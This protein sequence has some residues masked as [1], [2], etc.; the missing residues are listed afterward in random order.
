MR[1]ATHRGSV[2]LPEV[3]EMI[4]RVV[5]LLAIIHVTPRRTRDRGAAHQGAIG[6][7]G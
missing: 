3:I 4:V 7:V 2:T 5:V 1:V 6:S